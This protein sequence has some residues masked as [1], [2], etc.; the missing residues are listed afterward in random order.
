MTR[1]NAGSGQS[2]HSF[3]T[4]PRVEN[5]RSS[6]RRNSGYKTNFDAGYLYPVFWEEILPGDSINLKATMFA[7]MNTPLV[8]PIEN[9]YLESFFFF[10]PN[11]LLWDNWQ[12]FMGEKDNPDDTTEYVTPKLV[13]PTNGFARYGIADYLGVP[14]QATAGTT[15]SIV[16]FY[17]RAYNLIYKEW[18]RPEFI[19]D[20]PVIN[21]DN[22]PDAES[23]YPI[24]RRAKRF[25]YFTAALPFPQAG[26]PVSLPL[27]VSAPV[28]PLTAATAP[29]FIKAGSSPLTPSSLKADDPG[30][31]GNTNVLWTHPTNSSAV[32]DLYW[33]T[34]GL[35]ADLAA[36]TA[37]T[38]NDLRMAVQLQRFREREAR[39]GQRYTEILNVMFNVVSPDARLQR[40]EFLGGGSINISIN[41]QPDMSG[42]FLG[43]IGGYAIATGQTPRITQSFTEHGVILGLINVRADLNYQQG[44]NRHFQRDTRYDYFWPV[45]A[46]LGEQPILSREIYTDGTGS[47]EA[48]TGDYSIFGYQGRYDE[49]RYRHS[50]VTAKMRSTDPQTLDYWHLAQ[51]FEDRP[52]LN[53]EFILEN[54]PFDRIVQVTTEP[55]FTLDAVF[56][57]THVRVMP[58]Y[59]VPGLMDHF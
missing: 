25:D 44:T 50:F 13:S 22:G 36:A 46:H 18:F 6:F 57:L 45:L 40:P 20:S 4:I 55:N 17:H 42:N 30:G 39:G 53:D 49:Y 5:S 54:P 10:V 3:A 51:E 2:G 21:K 7:R 47:A 52:L 27:G 12:K 15:H 8:A 35:F 23:E 11:R 48:E 1:I 9:M 16:A 33:S 14:P 43:Y 56:D 41:P 32:N 28:L 59:G 26:D 34:P 24:R 58:T 38:I 31:T 19:T 29:T 37:V